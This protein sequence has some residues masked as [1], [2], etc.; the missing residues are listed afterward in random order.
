MQNHASRF[1]S[2]GSRAVL[3]AN[4]K[5]RVQFD[6]E[7]FLEN[8]LGI[9]KVKEDDVKQC[10]VLLNNN[11]GT[12]LN[13]LKDQIRSGDEPKMYPPLVS[14]LCTHDHLD[15][16]LIPRLHCPLKKVKDVSGYQGKY[17]VVYGVSSADRVYLVE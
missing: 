8:A 15:F 7:G 6:V 9:D 14:L 3:K 5:A 11:R 1:N 10:L 2:S 16:L 12:G 17:E 13:E 4:L